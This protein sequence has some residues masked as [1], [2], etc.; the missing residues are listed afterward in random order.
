MASDPNTVSAW[1]GPLL[2]AAAAALWG[3]T[4]I[5]AKTVFNHSA[6]L[7][8]SLA[9]LRLAIAC[10]CFLLL[11]RFSGEPSLRQLKPRQWIWLL[12]LGLTQGAYQSSYLGAVN[13]AGAGLA[14]LVALCISPVLVAIAA[15]PLLGERLTGRV[16]VALAGA[17]AGTVLLVHGDHQSAQ[18]SHRAWGIGLALVAAVVYAS[19]TLLSRHLA[20]GP[21]PFQTAFVC[22]LVGATTLLPGVLTAQQPQ[23]LA[24]ITLY[25]FLIVAYV[26]LIT[27]CVAYIFFFQGMRSTSATT[28]SII[29]T[30]EPLFAAILAWVVLGERLD[31]LGVAGA[32]T[33]TLAV[34]VASSGHQK[35]AG[36]KA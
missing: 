32:V 2:I 28:S 10:P 7:P 24:G 26:G 6:V 33:L 17:I 16:I 3:T 25:Q 5:A 22:F 19:F 29:V 8:Q 21:G 18:L 13:L 23:A 30:L 4:G 35:R 11:S 15:V 1:R 36:T 34:L 14:T 20:V 9:F 27:T 12:I 31:V